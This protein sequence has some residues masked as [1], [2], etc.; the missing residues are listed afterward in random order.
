MFNTKKSILHASS[1]GRRADRHRQSGQAAVE[2]LVGTVFFVLAIAF[3]ADPS[4]F[5]VNVDLLA[6]IKGYF[7]AFA[8]AISVAAT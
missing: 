6:A 5:G 7:Q 4:L 2:Y 3:V 1:D 8:Y